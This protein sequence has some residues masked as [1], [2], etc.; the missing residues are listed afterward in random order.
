MTMSKKKNL[1]LLL[2]TVALVLIA[3]S[4]FKFGQSDPTA[5]KIKKGDHIILIGITLAQE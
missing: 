3:L 2:N 4:A 5:L 1:K